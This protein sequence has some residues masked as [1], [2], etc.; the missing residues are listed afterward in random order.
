MPSVG[1]GDDQIREHVTAELQ[2]LE[3]KAHA[4]VKAKGWRFL[5][6]RRIAFLSPYMQASSWEPLRDRTLEYSLER[7]ER[8]SG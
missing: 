5:G 8:S 1:L 7:T 4:A 3:Q 2:Y 6:A